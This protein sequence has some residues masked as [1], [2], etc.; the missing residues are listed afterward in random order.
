MEI[1]IYFPA[2]DPADRYDIED[3]ID[4]VIEGEGEVT[5]GGTGFGDIGSNIDIEI[6]NENNKVTISKIKKV[7]LDLNM[8]R[9]TYLVVDGTKESL[10]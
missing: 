3:Y 10:Y 7:L 8:P 6:Y 1:F 5:G 2:I 4:E 9:E